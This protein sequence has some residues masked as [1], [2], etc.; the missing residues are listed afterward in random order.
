MSKPATVF[1]WASSGT[2]TDPGSGRYASGFAKE[3][4]PYEW[5]NWL[6]DLIAQWFLFLTRRSDQLDNWLTSLGQTP[7]DTTVGQLTSNFAS[8]IFYAR[9]YAR[10]AACLAAIRSGTPGTGTPNYKA[11]TLGKNGTRY[12]TVA[13]GASG[14]LEYSNN[15]GVAFT[16]ASA[17]GGYSGTFNGLAYSDADGLFVA[18]GTSGEIQTSPD[19]ITWTH[20]TAGSA[21]AGTFHS[22]TYAPSIDLF[23]AVGASGEIQSS[24]DGV[25]WTH[26]TP[27]AS[28]S[29]T[30]NSVVWSPALSMFCAV[31]ANGE[32]QTS[33]NG[34]A[35]THRTAGSSY[36]GS[37]LD[38]AAGY[39]RYGG[40]AAFVAVG[41]GTEI[42]ASADG[43]TW[44][45]V[46]LWD[47]G[48]TAIGDC[49]AVAIPSWGPVVVAIDNT[50]G[51]CEFLIGDLVTS[52]LRVPTKLTYTMNAFSKSQAYPTNVAQLLVAV[53]SS[54]QIGLI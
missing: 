12:V 40:H 34:T 30:F 7:D 38:V 9:E 37:F 22:V 48:V 32:I 53:G 19:G 27:A 2:K 23:V 1:E 11:A 29:G 45:H 41:S 44:V 26:R 47:S 51:A 39:V 28:F 50:D 25:T 13:A 52:F 54:G 36:S 49:T 46:G 31:G 17:A 20:R 33:T 3:R 8:E 18:V 16:S 15:Y 43:V 21:Y 35:W 4:V 5:V 42:Q 6:L 14:V 10:T 24:P